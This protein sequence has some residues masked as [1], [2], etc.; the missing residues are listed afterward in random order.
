MLASFIVG[1]PSLLKHFWITLT[2][3]ASMTVFHIQALIFIIVLQAPLTAPTLKVPL[4]PVSLH[5]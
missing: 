4:A 3:Q 1:M 5:F 2:I